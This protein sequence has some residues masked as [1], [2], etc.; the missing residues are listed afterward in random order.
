MPAA[1]IVHSAR[2][3]GNI[4]GHVRNEDR[5]HL[6]ETHLNMF[7]TSLDTLDKMLDNFIVH[8]IAKYRV[9]LKYKET[10]YDI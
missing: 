1:G 10:F 8:F 4:A 3:G 9:I 6:R 7:S 5:L 2:H